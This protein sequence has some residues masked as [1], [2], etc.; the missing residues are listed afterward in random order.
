MTPLEMIAEWRRGCADAHP[1]MG[2]RPEECQLCTRE[3][4]EAIERSLQAQEEA[5]A[6]IASMLRATRR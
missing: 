5:N 3:L 2:K 6:V 4:I 1:T